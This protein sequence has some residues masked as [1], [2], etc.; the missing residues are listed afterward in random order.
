MNLKN[1][2]EHWFENVILSLDLKKTNLKMI[3]LGELL[4]IKLNKYLIN[5]LIVLKSY[6]V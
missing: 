6:N 3:F 4:F 5:N 1:N 2:L